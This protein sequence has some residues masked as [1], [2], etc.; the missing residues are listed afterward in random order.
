MRDDRPRKLDGEVPAR[1][2]EAPARCRMAIHNTGFTF[3]QTFGSTN[4]YTYFCLFHGFMMQGT[5][6][7]N[8]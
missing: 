6:V 5:I 2:R 4:T 3:T 8:P 7:V 1:M